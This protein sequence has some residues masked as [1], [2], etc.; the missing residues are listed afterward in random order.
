MFLRLNE[1]VILT[2]IFFKLGVKVRIIVLN[3]NALFL[4]EL[5]IM[6]GFIFTKPE[7]FKSNVIYVF[8]FN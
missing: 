8:F 4:L 2:K 7:G 1:D 5:D 3:L 6:D